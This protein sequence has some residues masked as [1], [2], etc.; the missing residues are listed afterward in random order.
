MRKTNCRKICMEIHFVK[1]R[2]AKYIFALS[3]FSQNLPFQQRTM[4]K[5]Y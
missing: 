1:L 3:H 5:I 2:S 4:N